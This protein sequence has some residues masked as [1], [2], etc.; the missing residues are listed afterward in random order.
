MHTSIFRKQL[1]QYIAIPPMLAM[2]LLLISGC[3]NGDDRPAGPGRLPEV[4]TV[5]IKPQTVELT[6]ELPGRTAAH[7]VAEIRPQV[8]G[9]LQK[10]LFEEG[11]K[12]EAGQLLYQIDPATFEAHLNSAKASLGKA[13][14]NFAAVQSRAQRYK[15]L[16]AQDAVSQQDYDDAAAALKQARADIVYWEAQVK[17]ARINLDYT[18]VTAP[19]SGRISRSNIT[20]GALVTAYQALP[21]ATIQELDPIYVD[22]TQ[23]TAELLELRRNLASGRLHDQTQQPAVRIILEDGTPYSVNGQLQFRDVTSVDPATGSYVIRIVV[24]NPDHLMMPGMFVRAVIPEGIAEQA[25]L[26]TQQGV[27]RNTKGDPV[28]WIVDK[29]NIVQ[30][31]VLTIDRAIGNQWL[32]TAG[33]SSGDRVIVEGRLNVRPGAEVSPVAVDTETTPEKIS[34]PAH[35]KPAAE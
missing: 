18:G 34:S 14:A 22:V 6:T 32:I 25:I 35:P 26:I 17:N 10:R 28:A 24:P 9:I 16:L 20:D 27:T 1:L 11:A 8:N 4:G 3:K 31:K 33:L 13:R 15:E 7:R 19:I 2:L 29:N 30:E 21:L 23:S 5:T 12:V